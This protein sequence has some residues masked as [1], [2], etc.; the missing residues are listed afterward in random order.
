MDYC[1][2]EHGDLKHSRLERNDAVIIGAGP[3]G[4]FCALTAAARGAKILV[5]EKNA[6]AG[7]KLLLTGNGRCNITRAGAIED[8]PAR[9]GGRNRFVKPALLGFTNDDL[10]RFLAERGLE[11]VAEAD[12]RIFPRSF[13]P[14]DVLNVLLAECS[15]RGVRIRLGEAARGI[16]RV[17]GGF[18]VQTARGEY[19]ARRVVIATGGR[20]Y[21]GTGSTGDGYALARALGHTLAQPAP[22]LAP[23]VVRGHDFSGCAGIS[24]AGAGVTLLR[25]GETLRRARGDVLLTH[26]GLSGPAILDL[27]RYVRGGDV[28]ELSPA[29]DARREE[30]DA[31]LVREA[32]QHGRRSLKRCLVE[33]GIP[34][35]LAERILERCGIPAAL[36]AS[37]LDRGRRR[38]L[39]G[40]VTGL[41]FIVER[42]GG[43]DEA[44]A[45]RGGVRV[46][47]IRRTTME[48]RLV[49]GLYFA[50]EV[51]DVDGDS[52]GYNLQFAFS[53]GALAGRAAAPPPSR[54]QAGGR[55]GRPIDQTTSE[56]SA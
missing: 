41:P 22:A 31:L 52:G 4:L 16:A 42:T 28:I 23:V 14:G 47:E 33:C 27:S 8:F 17:R 2:Q 49:P 19:R 51:I 29:G 43:F 40:L 30:F 11:T 5:V 20:S 18:G 7:A 1:D 34:G 35:R 32:A 25:S 10:V 48:S 44:M 12:G 53:S 6:A 50:G 55:T 36:E 37:R 39:A 46:E 3:A 15:F 21:P 56:G 26:R 24:L 45:T 38:A 54:R 9:Y 13:D